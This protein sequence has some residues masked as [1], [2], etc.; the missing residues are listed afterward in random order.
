MALFTSFSYIHNLFDGYVHDMYP[1]INPNI[2]NIL[3]K[4][5]FRTK[6]II[7]HFNYARLQAFK[8][9]IKRGP[10]PENAYITSPLSFTRSRRRVGE[11]VNP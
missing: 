3:Q 8:I 5:G 6:F 4:Y 7:S 11:L 1:H 9:N 10:G 2:H